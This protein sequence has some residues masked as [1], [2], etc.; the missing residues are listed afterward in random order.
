MKI[1]EKGGSNVGKFV[2]F[3]LFFGHLGFFVCLVLMCI[4]SFVFST[5]LYNFSEPN[6]VRQYAPWSLFFC[7]GHTVRGEF[8][9]YIPFH[10]FI[11]IAAFD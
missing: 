5:L 10:D 11:G 1:I 4:M 8:F 7:V 2:S 6:I 9:R 3:F